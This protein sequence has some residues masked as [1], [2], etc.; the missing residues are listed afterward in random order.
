MSKE[1]ENLRQKFIDETKGKLWLEDFTQDVGFSDAYVE[2][3]EQQL[4]LYN[5]VGQSEQ[6]KKFLHYVANASAYVDRN[7]MNREAEELLDKLF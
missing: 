1:Q 7:K 2:W 4:L 5:V 3:L 6:L